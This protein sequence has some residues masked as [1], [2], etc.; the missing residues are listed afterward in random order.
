[1]FARGN[2]FQFLS[3]LDFS[4]SLLSPRYSF[5]YT[6]FTP[7][8]VFVSSFLLVQGSKDEITQLNSPKEYP[9]TKSL[10]FPTYMKLISWRGSFRVNNWVKNVNIGHR[11][12]FKSWRFERL[13]FVRT[14]WSSH[15]ETDVPKQWLTIRIIIFENTLSSQYHKY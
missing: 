11:K 14:M 12:E 10:M 5:F 15:E 7:F 8:G 1:M 13:A 6:S 3:S 4:W 9:V 2:P